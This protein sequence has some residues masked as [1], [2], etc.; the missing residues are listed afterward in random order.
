MIMGVDAGRDWL[1]RQVY[2]AFSDVFDQKQE[3][4]FM[5]IW[6]KMGTG[7]EILRVPSCETKYA[8]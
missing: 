1:D 7:I 4:S 5:G 6:G 2:K 8:P 3:V